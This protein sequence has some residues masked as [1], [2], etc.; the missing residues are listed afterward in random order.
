MKT[1]MKQKRELH[2]NV[3]FRPEKEGGF[4]ALV[5]VLPGCITYGRTLKETRRMATD[6]IEGYIVSLRK[7]KEPIPSDEETFISLVRL[8]GQKSVIYA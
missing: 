1:Q 2:F 7:H 5:P 3:I 4:T 8:P 6:A